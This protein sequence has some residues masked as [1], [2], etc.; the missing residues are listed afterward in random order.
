MGFYE[1]FE[2]FSQRET[3]RLLRNAIL[4]SILKDEFWEDWESE[5]LVPIISCVERENFFM[6]VTG[7]LT[8]EAQSIRGIHKLAF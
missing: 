8:S 1:Q 2:T 7:G 6:E 4:V 5:L 3:K